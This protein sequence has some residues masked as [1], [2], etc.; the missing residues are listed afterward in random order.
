MV[1]W[2][3]TFYGCCC[4]CS[5][6]K[7][8]SHDGDEKATQNKNSPLYNP[9]YRRGYLLRYGLLLRRK[10]A[11]ICSSWLLLVLLL[12][13]LLL[14]AFFRFRVLLGSPSVD[15]TSTIASLTSVAGSHEYLVSTLEVP[16]EDD[17]P[18]LEAKAARR[19][20]S[21]CFFTALAAPPSLVEEGFA[22]EEEGFSS[23]VSISMPPCC[24]W[25]SRSARKRWVE[26]LAAAAA[27]SF[28]VGRISV[29]RGPGPTRNFTVGTST[30]LTGTPTHVLASSMAR[31]RFS[32]VSIGK[33]TLCVRTPYDCPRGAE[34]T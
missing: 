34:S 28:A 33:G 16:W 21:A 23:S 24:C 22:L 26:T 29:D 32:S 15:S 7:K 3:S 27:T 12:L 19:S 5:F 8:K 18:E 13:L 11:P 17:E 1:L 6:F 14:L 9:L 25:E 4:C 20:R 2:E 10:E 30:T 31:W